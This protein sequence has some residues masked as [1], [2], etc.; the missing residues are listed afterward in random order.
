[1][2]STKVPSKFESSGMRSLEFAMWVSGAL[3]LLTLIISL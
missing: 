1:M 2:N 3:V